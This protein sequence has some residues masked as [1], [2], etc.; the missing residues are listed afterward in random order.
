MSFLK[1]SP[2]TSIDA[3]EKHPMEITKDKGG[4]LLKTEEE[5]GFFQVFSAFSKKIAGKILKG[6]FNFSSMQRPTLLTIPESHLQVLAQEYTLALEYFAI[7][8]GVHDDLE[9][10]RIIVAGMIGNMQFNVFRVKGKGPVNPVLGE[11]F[12]VC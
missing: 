11:T 8:G 5:S 2:F 1:L 12:S 3:I 7:A 6:K 4:I 10:L 9:R